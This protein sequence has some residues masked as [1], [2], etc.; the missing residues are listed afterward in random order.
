MKIAGFSI[1]LIMLAASATSNADTCVVSSAGGLESAVAKAVQDGGCKTNSAEYRERYEKYRGTSTNFHVIRI[2]YSGE[3]S[4]TLPCLAGHDGNPLI[5]YAGDKD[6]VI[7]TSGDICIDGGSGLVILD[8]LRF[9]TDEIKISSSQNV[10]LNSRLAG[11]RIVING[12]SNWLVLT[13][14]D[15]STGNGL[16][17]YGDDNKVTSSTFINNAEYGV[18]ISGYKNRIKNSKVIKNGAGGVY[19][20]TCADEACETP[21]TALI[22]HTIFKNNNGEAISAEKATLPAPADVMAIEGDNDWKVVGNFNGPAGLNLK[23][24]RI[25]LFIKNGPFIAETKA[26]DPAT[27]QFVFS[28]ERPYEVNGK[29]Y[30]SL[31]FAATAVDYEN[32]DTSAFSGDV[33]DDEA[34]GQTDEVIKTDEDWDGDGIP[35]AQEDYNHNG[36]VDFG[37]TDPRKDDTDS[38]GLSDGEERLHIGTNPTNSDSDGDCLQDGLELGKGQDG[39]KGEAAAAAV[40]SMQ[41]MLGKTEEG[42][43]SPY[44]KA[45]LKKHNIL[46]PAAPNENTPIITDPTSSD[47]DDDGLKDGEED[48][49]FN[50]RLDEGETNAKDP[51]TDKDTLLDGDESDL[52]ANGKVD[53]N[54]TD[55]L[56][57]DTDGDGV[58]DNVEVKK[59]GSL[60]N[61]CDSDGDGLSDGIEAGAVNP[62]TKNP[63][64]AGLQSAGT[65]FA[66]ISILSPIKTDSDGDGLADGHEDLN[67]NGW[68]DPGEAD[69]TTSDTDEDGISDYVETMLDIDRDKIPDVDVQLITNGDKCSP[70]ESAADLDCDGIPNARDSDSDD[71]G[72]FDYEEGINTDA[73]ND[74]IPDVWQQVQVSCGSSGG[75]SGGGGTADAASQ[76]TSEPVKPSESSSKKIHVNSSGACTLVGQGAGHHARDAG[77]YA[78]GAVWFDAAYLFF[79]LLMLFCRRF[80]SRLKVV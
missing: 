7:L 3:L 71:D 28:V 55:P 46:N 21:R 51:D 14:I 19:V 52:N 40:N 11:G 61:S 65:N 39:V 66:S 45:I 6:E 47:T 32:N 80:K 20:K 57:A 49:N 69:P 29:K 22:S 23:A 36:R 26:V 59:L 5:I 75:T 43:I 42:A 35:N 58:T 44:C 70:P 34:G 68:L 56:L 16:E 50:G 77:E 9:K 41:T 33:K 2:D 63:E 13:K 8:N 27:G 24:V 15:S 10:I 67:H 31:E 1:F 37:E 48:W 73:N 60:P 18:Y 53:E 64:C 17:I 12:D 30:D 38:D 54:E 72:C 25:E 76:P 4:A 62:N 74:G 79:A 78:Q